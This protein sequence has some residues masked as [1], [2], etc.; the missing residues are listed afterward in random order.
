ML[1]PELSPIEVGT[2]AP[3][4]VLPSGSGAQVS[5]ADYR[6]RSHVVLFF[7]RTYT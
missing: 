6:G 4:F 5:L 7:V 3:V 2:I 1:T